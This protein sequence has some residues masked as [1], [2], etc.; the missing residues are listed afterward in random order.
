MTYDLSCQTFHL[1]RGASQTTHVP[2]LVNF[3]VSSKVINK[4]NL[5]S[6]S[7]HS[8][9]LYNEAPCDVFSKL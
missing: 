4:D 8:I 1:A 5:F 9:I 7:W 2:A 6:S 3:S